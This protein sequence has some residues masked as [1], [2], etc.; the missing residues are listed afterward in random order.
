MDASSI[1]LLIGNKISSTH[2][3]MLIEKLKNTDENK[4]SNISY[5]SFKSPILA[6]VLGLF[7]GG[8]GVDRFYQGNYILGAIKLIIFILCIFGLGI[9][10][11][12]FFFLYILIDLFF[13][14]KAVQKDNFNKILK[15]VE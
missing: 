13:V 5:L 7:F 6:L 11:G 2:K 9:F 8:L 12:P 4:L 1:M 14:Y 3:L 15:A 10:I